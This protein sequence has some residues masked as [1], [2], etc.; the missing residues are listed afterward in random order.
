MKHPEP[1]EEYL[2]HIVEAIDRATSYLQPVPDLDAFQEN[3]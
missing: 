1:V 2:E 3:R